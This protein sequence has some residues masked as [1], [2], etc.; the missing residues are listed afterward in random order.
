MRPGNA[1]RKPAACT[2]TSSAGPKSMTIRGQRSSRACSQFRSVGPP[3]SRAV[4]F[5]RWV[6]VRPS[7]LQRWLIR[8]EHVA[9]LNTRLVHSSRWTR[10]DAPCPFLPVRHL[11]NM[12][13]EYSWRT[14]VWKGLGRHHMR[15]AT[16]KGAIPLETCN[17]VSRKKSEL[18]SSRGSRVNGDRCAKHCRC[19]SWS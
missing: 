5:W 4:W 12:G 3:R 13:G 18:R 16:G 17:C 9:R 6:A 10:N 11:R 2:A 15:F 8:M 7:R 19:G 14:P 1:G